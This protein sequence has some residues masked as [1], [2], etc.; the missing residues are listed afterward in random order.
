MKRNSL[1]LRP[2]LL[3]ALVVA[4]LGAGSAHAA[5]PVTITPELRAVMQRD[6]GISP[7]QLPQF[8]AL[9]SQ[10]DARQAQLRA[11]L[12]DAY[13]GSWLEVDAVG[14]PK[15]VVAATGNARALRVDGVE[16]RQARFSLTQLDNAMSKLDTLRNRKVMGSLS[17]VYSWRV[18]QKTNSVVVTT[19]PTGLDT[20][21]DFVAASGAD[22]QAVRFETSQ[23]RPQTAADLRGGDRQNMSSGGYCSIGFAVSRSGVRYYATAGHCGRVGVTTTGFNG[24]SLGIYDGSSFPGR[25]WAV[26]RITNT[27]GWVSRPWV[28]NYAGGNVIVRGNSVAGVG[29]S[30]CRSGARTGYRCGVI[31]ATNVT[32]NYPQGSVSGL[33]QSNACAG[34]GDSGGSWITPTGQAQGVYSGGQFPPSGENCSL[35]SPVNWFQPLNPILA[36]YNMTLLVG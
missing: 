6:L 26:V 20:G 10:L 31:T 13:A 27:A 15:L 34:Q 23:F 35:S 33:T 36:N 5:D 19:S 14:V 3:S 28:N 12:G 9:E 32:V 29:A 22:A 16:V 8:L 25:D 2:M 18:D 7:G 4:A 30:V 1:R 11:Q 17:D 21:I 24:T